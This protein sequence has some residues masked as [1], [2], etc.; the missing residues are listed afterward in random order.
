M[1]TSLRSSIV[2]LDL[3]RQTRLVKVAA[4]KLTY[5]I[6]E[7]KAKLSELLRA[8]R[9]GHRI[10]ITD[11]GRE[12]ARVVPIAEHESLED[13]MA[14]LVA[15]GILSPPALGA[16]PGAQFGVSKPGALARFLQERD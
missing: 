15:A 12:V 1:N 4:V 7:A 9:M 11:R 5:S 3:T 13:R 16:L 8:V 10:T 6:Y 2:S 14:D